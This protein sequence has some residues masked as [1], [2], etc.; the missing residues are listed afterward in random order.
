MF[1]SKS[2]LNKDD[3]I[4]L[5]ITLAWLI[6]VFIYI[7]VTPVAALLQIAGVINLPW[8]SLMIPIMTYNSVIVLFMASMIILAIID[9]FKS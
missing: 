8:W 3:R 7:V 5:Y 2:T 9:A 4:A 1:K 6:G